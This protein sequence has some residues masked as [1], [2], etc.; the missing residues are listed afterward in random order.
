[1]FLYI[2]AIHII[3]VVSWF[4]GLFYIIRL[5]IYHTE[6]SERPENEQKILYPQYQLMEKR[7]WSIITTPAMILTLITGFTML[8]LNPAYLKMPWMHVKLTFILGLVIYHFICQNIMKGLWKENFKWTSTQLRIWNE[9][10]TIFL[11]AIVFL[12]V[13]KNT[14]SWVWG[15]IGLIGLGITLMIAVKLYKKAR[16]S[17]QQK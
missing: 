5:F 8:Y 3:F 9:V 2:K 13:L 17:N 6:A 16:T 12:V 14:L 1:M 7:L 15:V 11:V 10:A 4:A